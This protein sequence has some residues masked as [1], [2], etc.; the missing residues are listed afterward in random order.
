MF[1]LFRWIYG[2]KPTAEL[3]DNMVLPPPDAPLH[4]DQAGSTGSTAGPSGADPD[5]YEC[6]LWGADLDN[7]GEVTNVPYPFSL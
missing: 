2:V 4:Y 6:K 3:D 5:F 1:L 7:R